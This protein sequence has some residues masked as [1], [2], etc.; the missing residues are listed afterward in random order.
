LKLE[1]SVLSFLAPLSHTLPSLVAER[2]YRERTAEDAVIEPQGDLIESVSASNDGF[3]LQLAGAQ[4]S[5]LVQLACQNRIRAVYEVRSPQAVGY[6]Y[7]DAGR[8]MHAEC[9]ERVGLDA[10]VF[11][12][13]LTA[14]TIL[15]T[16]R[17]W[18]AEA[19]IHMG[20]DALLLT[21]AQRLDEDG[22]VRHREP[23]TRIVAKVSLSEPPPL[24]FD[25]TDFDVEPP[26]AVSQGDSVVVAR[27]TPRAVRRATGR[28]LRIARA[29]L[30][31][32]VQHGTPGTSAEL[33]DAALF[34]RRATENLAR[35]LGLG[36]CDA[37]C[38]RGRRETLIVFETTT[39]VGV[40]GL[41]EAVFP[42]TRKLGLE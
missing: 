24:P 13:G 19:S 15:P 33:A 11:L 42:L 30:S 40:V 5:D 6:L 38:L 14:G 8:L 20:A 32:S 10:M 27:G 28:G 1:L 7:F 17:P 25:L 22:E 3:S 9:G 34:V 36:R 18:P 41:A 16:A 2:A 31:G 39:V 21:A 4:L 37:A 35:F 23:T 12:L 26:A 29:S